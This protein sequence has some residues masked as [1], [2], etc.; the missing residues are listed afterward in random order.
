MM[1]AYETGG[2]DFL[3]LIEG[4]NAVLE[5]RMAQLEERRNLEMA[6]SRLGELCGKELLP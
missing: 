5:Y 4:L 2:A 3:S 6:V 1:A